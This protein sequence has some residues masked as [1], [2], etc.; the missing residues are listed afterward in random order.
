MDATLVCLSVCLYVS[1]PFR[2]FR[3]DR[4]AN[5]LI[6]FLSTRRISRHIS[7]PKFPPPH[8]P[9]VQKGSKTLNYS[10]FLPTAT[11]VHITSVPHWQS[12]GG[13]QFGLWTWRVRQVYLGWL[14]IDLQFRIELQV[15]IELYKLC[16]Q[17]RTAEP[18]SQLGTVA[19]RYHE[20]VR[21]EAL[22]ITNLKCYGHIEWPT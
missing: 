10:A 7:F 14:S 2:H 3:S 19:T 18:E 15:A 5:R 11:R 8:P 21:S 4:L 20:V 13:R 9:R 6:L 16:Q 17:Y 1:R 12:A 22:I